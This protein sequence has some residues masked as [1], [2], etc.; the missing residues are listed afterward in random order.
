[1]S[2]KIMTH[3][4]AGFPDPDG[5][6]KALK[7]LK[8]G[9][10]DI[11]ELQIPFS[12]PTADGP[13]ITNACEQAI[14]RGFKV[15]QTFDYIQQARQEGFERIIVMTYANIAFNYGIKKYVVDLKSAGVEA[16]L[17]PDLPLEDEEGFY[18]CA[19]ENGLEP[20]PVAVVGMPAGRLELLNGKP[21]KKIY[22]SLRAGTTGKTTDISQETQEFLDTL[23]KYE[24][25]AGFGIRSR[26]QVQLLQGHA[27]AAVIGS[28]FTSL[29]Q[30]ACLSKKD[31]GRE[32]KSAMSILK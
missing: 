32:L 18:Q 4:V 2:I 30:D 23:S 20:M 1:M 19:F 26:E 8:E 14:A 3:L 6:R 11:L 22:I 15:H 7:G 21:F 9:G 16:A 5:F 27:E 17:V 31:I 13:V 24:R 29:I 25:F 10:S 12:D 28:Y